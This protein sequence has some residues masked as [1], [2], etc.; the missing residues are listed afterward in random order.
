MPV[1][2]AAA[3]STSAAVV[4]AAAAAVLC[5]GMLTDTDGQL[6]AAFGCMGG[7][8]QPQGHLQVWE[9]EEM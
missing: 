6:V 4:A 8:M 3:A 1:A 5:A 9:R 7:Y 2:A